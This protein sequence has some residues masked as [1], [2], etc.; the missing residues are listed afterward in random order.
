MRKLAIGVVSAALVGLAAIPARAQ[1]TFSAS[2]PSP[3]LLPILAAIRE[4]NSLS[5]AAKAY[6]EG[7]AL[8][9][10]NAALNAAYMKKLLQLGQ[11]QTAAMPAAVLV[12]LQTGDG[13]AYSVL[14]YAACRQN[15]L[16]TAVTNYV[17]AAGL[18]VD[19]ES[20]QA[21]LGQLVAWIDLIGAYR[22]AGEANAALGKVKAGLAAKP[23][24]AAAYKSILDAFAQ[25]AEAN[26]AYQKRVEAALAE[27]LAAERKVQD[28]QQEIKSL[29]DQRNEHQALKEQYDYRAIDANT[30]Q[31]LKIRARAD[32]D[33][34][35]RVIAD[36]NRQIGE[37]Q[38]GLQD[39][40]SALEKK[41]QA[42]EAARAKRPEPVNLGKLFRWVAPTADGGGPATN[43]SPASAPASAPAGGAARGAEPDA[44][45]GQAEHLPIF[46]LARTAY[47]W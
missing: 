8:D 40:R 26:A 45:G 11:A 10:R 47:P 36:L 28:V 1:T 21:N 16:P 33:R 38:R 20:L 7:A 2:A 34:E 41:R 17:K 42:W 9:R 12:G 13:L 35:A 19:D 27:G 15:N 24:Y 3:A 32:S 44:R 39:A 43:L 5:S 31:P 37:S 25:Y 46:A 6:S 4:A 14:G 29:T 22:P 23:A 18:G 30:P